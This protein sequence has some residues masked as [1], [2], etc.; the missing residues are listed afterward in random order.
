MKALTI[1]CLKRYIHKVNKNKKRIHTAKIQRYQIERA[2]TS[3]NDAMYLISSM[4]V[5]VCSLLPNGFNH[6]LLPFVNENPE[7]I[8]PLASH[9]KH[10][11]Y[12]I[13]IHTITNNK[14]NH[15]ENNKHHPSILIGV[16]RRNY[17]LKQQQK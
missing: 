6:S 4:C 9:N 14:N 15:D 12:I 5:C 17:S 1:Y 10:I 16:L 3:F 2:C 11:I 13:M 8:V 7:K